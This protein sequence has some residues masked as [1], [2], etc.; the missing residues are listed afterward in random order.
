[1]KRES[2]GEK[3]SEPKSE[4]RRI[5][6]PGSNRRSSDLIQ[7]VSSKLIFLERFLHSELEQI[8]T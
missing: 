7:S 6:M 8:F 5:V 4:S 3:Q 1:M 2:T